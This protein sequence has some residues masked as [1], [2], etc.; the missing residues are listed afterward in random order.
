[1]AVLKPARGEVIDVG[2]GEWVV[3]PCCRAT[4]EVM[5]LGPLHG[6]ELWRADLG[7]GRDDWCNHIQIVRRGRDWYEVRFESVREQLLR[8][9]R[10]L[11][12]LKRQR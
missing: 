2:R 3:C 6:L 7:K 5:D 4:Y 8:V 10:R 12:R 9:R 11:A 1:M